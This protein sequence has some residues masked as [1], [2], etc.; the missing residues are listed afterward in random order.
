MIRRAP[1]TEPRL[2][3]FPR[4]PGR[5]INWVKVKWKFDVGVASG[6]YGILKNCFTAQEVIRKPDEEYALGA[7]S[8][9]VGGARKKCSGALVR[10]KNGKYSASFRG[11]ARLQMPADGSIMD[12]KNGSR[13]ERGNF[14]GGGGIKFKNQQMIKVRA[15]PGYVN[16][17]RIEDVCRWSQYDAPYHPWPV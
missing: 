5:P 16:N 3:M 1:D 12:C 15:F 4:I 17:L 7:T 10:N 14:G 2:H 8:V 11:G 9:W 6:E 13:D